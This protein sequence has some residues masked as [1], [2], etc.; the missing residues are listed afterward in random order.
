MAADTA[1]QAP[2]RL[3]LTAAE[4]AYLVDRLELAMPPGWEPSTDADPPE[5]A[6]LVK[7]GVLRGDGDLL[8]VHPSVAI[9]L[10]ILAGPQVMLDTTTTIGPLGQHCLHAIAGQLG[11]SLF[12]LEAG[13]VEL[14]LYAAADLGRELVRAVPSEVDSEISPALGAGR[15]HDEFRGRVPLAAL[16][17]LGVAELLRGADSAAPAEVLAEL[18]LPADTARLAAR[19]AGATDGA[20]VCLI[21]A[22]VGDEV[23]TGRVAWLHTGDGWLGLRPDER[24]MVLVEPVAREDLGVWVAPFVAEALGDD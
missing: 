10:R 18:R 16:H 12:L 6:D 4:Y 3:R 22:R 9:N 19:I 20:L 1:T 24:R 17:E 5:P 14:S 11:A 2:H 23:R 8:A 15:R 13:A 7:R 21:T